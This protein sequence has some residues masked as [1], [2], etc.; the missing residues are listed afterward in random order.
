MTE[1]GQEPAS[2]SPV[3]SADAA[4]VSLPAPFPPDELHRHCRDIEVLFRLNPYY[5]FDVWRQTGSD[6]FH[7]EFENQSNQTRQILDLRIEINSGHGITVNYNGGIKKCTVFTIEPTLQGS[8]MTVTDDYDLLPVTER[9]ERKAEVDRSL[10]AWAESLRL[11]FLRR[12]RWSWLP[13]WRW[14]IRRV[15]MPMKPSTRRIVWFIYLISVAEF[16]FF[17][18]VLL[19]WLVEQGN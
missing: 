11:Y 12:K 19:I 5:Y 3:N 6:T 10:K 17:L 13:G 8:R 18:F 1:N 7:A 4:W 14:Y 9:E 2:A 16:F 15:W